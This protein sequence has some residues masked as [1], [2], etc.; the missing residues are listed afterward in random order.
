MAYRVAIEDN[1][2]GFSLPLYALRRAVEVADADGKADES[3][4]ITFTFRL[5]EADLQGDPPSE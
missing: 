3:T 1:H 4:L 2:V 5:T